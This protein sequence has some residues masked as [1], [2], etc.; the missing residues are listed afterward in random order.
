MGQLES[1]AFTFVL[2]AEEVFGLI[3]IGNHGAKLATEKATAF[4]A[5]ALGA[6]EDG[7]RRIEA[8]G[9]SDSREQGRSEY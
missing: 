1:W 5:G 8:N 4:L 7:A 9:K 6:I 2:T 3:C